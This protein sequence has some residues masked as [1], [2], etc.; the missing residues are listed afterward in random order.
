MRKLLPLFTLIVLIASMIPLAAFSDSNPVYYYVKTGDYGPLNMREA[1]STKAEI[2]A[3]IP[4]GE[5]V[6]LLDFFINSTWASCNYKGHYGYVMTRYLS[7]DKPH[8][9][10]GPGPTPKPTAKPSASM[11]TGFKP[12]Y[13]NAIVR[14]STPAGFVHMR[15]A[16]SKEEPIFQDYYAGK[17]LQVF[18]AN[19]TWCQVYDT[20]THMFGYMM[21]QFL[22]YTGPIG[23]GDGLGNSQQ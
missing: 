5:K 16:P 22:T 10:P 19:D 17:S 6:E 8:P 7:F 2:I 4:Y 15:W 23:Y 18:Y 1:A 11:F 21:K 13:Y 14:P 20:A 3:Q 9:K 12:A